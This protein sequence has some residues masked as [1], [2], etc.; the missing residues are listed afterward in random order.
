MTG[1]ECAG[2]NRRL[3]LHQSLDN[4]DSMKRNSNASIKLYQQHGVYKVQSCMVWLDSGVA[5]LR[6]SGE[7]YKST[8]AAI[9]EMKRRT[10]HLLWERGSTETELDVNWEIET[11]KDSRA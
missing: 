6:G 10:M 1:T 5:R 2:R 4:R 3:P 7:N 9:G 11:E 8:E